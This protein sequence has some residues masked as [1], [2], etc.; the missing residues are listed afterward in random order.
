M[1]DRVVLQIHAADRKRGLTAQGADNE[2]EW[3]TAE[4]VV[5]S[6]TIMLLRTT[7]ENLRGKNQIHAYVA[8]R[9]ILGLLQSRDC[10]AHATARQVSNMLWALHEPELAAPSKEV[11]SAVINDPVSLQDLSCQDISNLFLAFAQ[12]G[13]FLHEAQLHVCLKYLLNKP[14]S[15]VSYQPFSNSACSLAYKGCLDLNLFEALLEP[16][17]AM[18]NQL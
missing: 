16:L 10:M 18:S 17:Y 11:E 8:S 9:H 13:F 14:V 1:I 15:E 12:L 5:S 4:A 3:P 7:M 6:V 2:E